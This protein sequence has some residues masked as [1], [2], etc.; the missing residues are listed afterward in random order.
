MSQG[1]WYMDPCHKAQHYAEVAYFEQRRGT[2][3]SKSL[4]PIR[5]IIIEETI[6]LD[7]CNTNSVLFNS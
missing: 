6:L 1:P 4:G 7:I 5:A 3:D 2:N